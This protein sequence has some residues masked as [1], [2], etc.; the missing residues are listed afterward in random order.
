MLKELP[1]FPLYDTSKTDAKV[2]YTYEEP[3]PF[4]IYNEGNG[5]WRVEGEKVERLFRNTDFKD[6]DSIMRFSRAMSRM[7]LD[8]A[9]REK[10]CRNGDRVFIQDYSFEFMD[11]E[12]EY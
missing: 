7:K 6:D 8:D 3:Q 4:T 1:Q 12:D 5:I 9:L 10:G 2:L 11:E